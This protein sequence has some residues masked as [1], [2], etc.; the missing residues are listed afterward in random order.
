MK[1]HFATCER[2]RALAFIQR[3]YPDREITDTDDSAGPLLDLVERDVVRVQ[4]PSMHARNGQIA[5]I[6]G[7]HWD[8]SHRGTVARAAQQFV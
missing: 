6:P 2:H 3:V 1:L 8:E 5:I 4:D 7:H